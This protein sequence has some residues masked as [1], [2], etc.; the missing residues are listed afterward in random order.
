M[1]S[2]QKTTSPLQQFT[3]TVGVLMATGLVGA[4]VAG[5]AAHAESAKKLEEAVD[6]TLLTF[7]ASSKGATALLERARGVLVVPNLV[8]GAVGVGAEFGEGALRVDG[9]TVQYYN[10]LSGSIGLQVGGQSRSLVVLFFD[11]DALSGF[12]T[13]G[14]WQVGVDGQILVL[15]MNASGDLNTRT[16][17]A[18][19]AAVFLNQNGLMAGVSLEGSKFTRISKR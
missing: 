11:D 2:L 9:K 1:R 17:N 13:S 8:E 15:K 16:G 4:L 6:N 14:G 7:K 5:G 12:M 3:R 19:I 10:K 18:P